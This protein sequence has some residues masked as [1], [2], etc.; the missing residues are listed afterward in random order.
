VVF[1]VEVVANCFQPA[2]GATPW[3]TF[4]YLAQLTNFW[5]IDATVVRFTTGN[6]LAFSCFQGVSVQSLCIAPLKTVSSLGS[7]TVISQ[8]TLSWET[9]DTP[10]NEGPA[11]LY[12]GG[13]TFIVYS[14]SFCWTSSY[15]L[16]VLTWNGG[17]PTKAASWAKT[18][19]FLKSANGNYGNGHNG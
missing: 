10:V 19:P 16:G 13:K 7:T 5:A 15:A 9:V 8:P 1:V 2:G 14:A 3:D 18:G 6:Y 4:S 17:D 11:A 12:H